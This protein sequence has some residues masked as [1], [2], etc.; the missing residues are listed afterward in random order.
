[1]SFF[2][3][4]KMQSEAGQG[5]T[6]I[7]ARK[8]AERKAGN[9]V[10]WWGIGNS[11]GTAVHDAARLSG[12]HLPVLF[13]KMLSRPKAQDSAPDSVVLWTKW[14]DGDGQEQDVPPHVLVTSRAAEGKRNHYA[15]ACYSKSAL[16]IKDH[17]P[18]DPTN[19]R[20]LAGKCP[21]A[22]Q[23]TALLT[24]PIAPHEQG[25]YSEGF[26][27]S[28]IAPYMVKLVDGRLLDPTE[29]DLISFWPLG[30]VWDDLVQRLRG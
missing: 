6:A 11:L 5:L 15:L 14:V 16:T 26:Q 18:F 4:S 23:V 3:W 7:I 12:G 1:M 22:S 29:R 8:E 19:C 13:S 27:V 17:G 24:G 25:P 9:G 20:T 10:F 21:G 30:G 28:L 2:V